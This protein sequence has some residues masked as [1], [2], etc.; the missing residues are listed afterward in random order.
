MLKGHRQRSDFNRKMA[1]DALT[2]MRSATDFELVA[3]YDTTTAAASAWN[4][5]IAEPRS[6]DGK[7]AKFMEDQFDRCFYILR[8]VAVTLHKSTLEAPLSRQYQVE[9]ARVLLDWPHTGGGEFPMF[10]GTAHMLCEDE[11]QRVEAQR[12]ARRARKAA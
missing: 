10:L 9:I 2:Q 12:E 3:L 4:G 8:A 6:G 11:E 7:V 5:G 1:D